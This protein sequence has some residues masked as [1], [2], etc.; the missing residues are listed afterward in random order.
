MERRATGVV[1]EYLDRP[2]TAFDGGDQGRDVGALRYVAFDRDG[3]PAERSNRVCGALRVGLATHVIHGDV[4][5]RGGERERNPFADAAARARHERHFAVQGRLRHWAAQSIARSAIRL[6][7]FV[8]VFG[9]ASTKR[10]S[11]GRLYFTISSLQ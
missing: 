8:P 4:A 2:E 10:T 5:A 9:S 11:T 1:D 6:I 7:L 3:P